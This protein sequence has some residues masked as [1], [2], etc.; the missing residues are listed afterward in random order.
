MWQ[1]TIGGCSSLRCPPSSS[2]SLGTTSLSATPGRPDPPSR[3]F[4]WS[5]PTTPRGFPCCVRF[6]CVHAVATT[7]AQRLDHSSLIPQSYQ[8]SP[9]WRS[10]RPVQRPFRGLLSVHSRYGLHTRAVTIFATRFTGGFN[11]F[12]TSTVAPVASGWS[13]CRVGLSPTGKAPP[14]HGARQNQPFVGGKSVVT[15]NLPFITLFE[16]ERGK[17]SKLRFYS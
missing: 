9:K 16:E 7:P 17:T 10:G 4:G 8:P 11:H 2:P 5:S 12:V 1:V 14:Y 15:Q 6:P 3:A 13:D